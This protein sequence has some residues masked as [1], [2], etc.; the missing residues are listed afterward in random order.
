MEKLSA[1]TS[2]EL[3]KRRQKNDGS[4]P[5]KLLVIYNRKFK[6]YKTEFSFDPDSFEKVL[7]PKPRGEFKDIRFKL[8]QIEEKAHKIIK[9]LTSFSYEAFEKKFLAKN[10]A[11]GNAFEIFDEQIVQIKA[12]GRISTAGTYQ[13]AKNSFRK[14][15][16]KDILSFS[17]INVRFLEEYERWAIAQGNSI[18][19]V[20]YYMRCL[21][22]VFNLAILSGEVNRDIYPFGAK[23]NGFYQP[24]VQNNIKKALDLADIKKIFEYKPDNDIERYYKD[25]WIFSYLCNGMNINDI[26]HLK[27]KN[28]EGDSMVFKRNKT[29]HSRKTSE[30]Q[31]YMVDEARAIIKKWGKKPQEFDS[32][33]FKGITDQMNPVTKLAAIKQETKQCNKYMNRVA[34]Q[35]G[36]EANITTYVARHSFATVLKDSNEPIALI[37]EALGHSSIAVTENYLKSFQLEKRKKAAQKLVNW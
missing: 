20:G 27:Y 12:E 6:R 21:R 25:L 30:I 15:H 14:F 5:V 29:I 9:S 10:S 26:L 13:V 34:K 16:G 7:A 1:T 17:E 4:Y 8:N 19:T 3:D 2:F 33:I 37:S 35:L 11:K 36:I 28:I 18:T 23:S 31:V 32:Y 24:P 22:R